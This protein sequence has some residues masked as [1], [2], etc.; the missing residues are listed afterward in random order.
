AKAESV[1]V[2]LLPRE[3]HGVLTTYPDGAPL[4]GVAVTA[5]TEETPNKPWTRVVSDSSGAYTIPNPPVG[6]AYL[7]VRCPEGTQRPDGLMA[8]TS[9]NVELAKPILFDMAIDRRNC[10]D[11]GG[12]PQ[13]IQPHFDAPPMGNAADSTRWRHATYPSSEDEAAVYRTVLS[14]AGASQPGGKITLV[15]ATTKSQ[16]TAANCAD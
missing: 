11:P 6:V 13:G 15:Y 2:S 10:D 12:T 1:R 4:A 7:T 9:A 3:I 16:C 14:G 5:A 8:V